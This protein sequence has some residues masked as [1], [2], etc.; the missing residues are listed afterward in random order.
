MQN[1][2]LFY[3]IIWIELTNPNIFSLDQAWSVQK[4]GKDQILPTGDKDPKEDPKPGVID[5][6]QQNSFDEYLMAGLPFPLFFFTSGVSTIVLT[7]ITENLLCRRDISRRTRMSSEMQAQIAEF[8][9]FRQ[10]AERILTHL[11]YSPPPANAQ[12]GQSHSEW[13]NALLT[14]TYE[15]PVWVNEYQTTIR[16]VFRGESN[17]TMAPA[18]LAEQMHQ[19]FEHF[20]RV[21]ELDSTHATTPSLWRDDIIQSFMNSSDI[22]SQ[23]STFNN[24]FNP[25]L[26]PNE[27]REDL[28]RRF[29]G[30]PPPDVREP[31]FFIRLYTDPNTF[32]YITIRNE[33]L[34]A[35]GDPR[36]AVYTYD[37]TRYSEV[38]NPNLNPQVIQQP[39]S[40][41]ET[42]S[43]FE[44]MRTF[45]EHGMAIE[46][47]AARLETETP[48]A[49]MVRAMHHAHPVT[50]AQIQTYL[51]QASPAQARTMVASVRQFNHRQRCHQGPMFADIVPVNQITAVTHMVGV[52]HPVVPIPVPRHVIVGPPALYSLLTF[53]IGTQIGRAFDIVFGRFQRQPQA[54]PSFWSH[55]GIPQPQAG[56][57]RRALPQPQQPQGADGQG[58]MMTLS[59]VFHVL[60]AIYFAMTQQFSAEGPWLRTLKALMSKPPKK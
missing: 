55:F 54:R 8:Q 16:A 23:M 7:R 58:G 36:P 22:Q 15:P 11:N 26:Y 25:E 2:Y 14:P 6:A 60:S 18:E 50:N 43:A 30:N 39:A 37:G 56:P 42:P 24:F 45:L 35:L 57:V 20:A 33:D 3:H 32:N 12:L 34:Q 29:F 59:N 41:S 48:I 49:M 28:I 40:V 52:A 1:L 27:S 13:T 4:S 21:F 38:A 53:L 9:Q 17:E 51:E 47:Y 10:V 19:F 31:Q 44:L 5:P 46:R